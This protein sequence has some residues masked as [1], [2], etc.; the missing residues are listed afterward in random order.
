MT[1]RLEKTLRNLRNTRDFRAELL[2]IA[3]DLAENP[4]AAVI[5]VEDPAISEVTVRDEWCRMLAAV[6]PEITARMRLELKPAPAARVKTNSVRI[7]VPASEL[8]PL[9]RPNYRAEVLRLLVGASVTNHGTCSVKGLIEQIGASQTPIREALQALKYCG[10]LKE[11][12]GDQVDLGPENLSTELIAMLRA[13][14]QMLRFRFERGARLRTPVELLDRAVSLLG[15]S[16][17]PTWSGIALSGVPVAHAEVP[18]LNIAGMPRLD[19]VAFVPRDV[20]TFD[21][22]AIRKLSDGLEY[23]PN[24][25]A[26]APVV[27]TLVR[28]DEHETRTNVIEGVRCASVMDVL[29]AMIDMGLRE[30]ASVYASNMRTRTAPKL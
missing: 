7:G 9:D 6:K 30:E 19:L 8:I 13:R 18:T 26:T 16:Q 20:R 17:T 27:V 12:F 11:R 4:I 25:L 23:E 5:R 14:S 24:V 1:I 28:A 10:L 2:S 15:S 22:P 21:A 29:L 3:A